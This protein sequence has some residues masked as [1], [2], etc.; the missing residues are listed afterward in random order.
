MP[1]T[2]GEAVGMRDFDQIAITARATGEADHAAVRCLHRSSGAA[3]NIDAVMH[4]RGA[5]K[6][7]G[8]ASEAGGNRRQYRRR[9]NFGGRRAG[10]WT[11]GK[12]RPRCYPCAKDWAVRAG[13]LSDVRPDTIGTR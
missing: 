4:P 9:A 3:G 13:Q 10:G 7:I 12:P 2:G 6:R 5:V 11:G 8:A 1:V